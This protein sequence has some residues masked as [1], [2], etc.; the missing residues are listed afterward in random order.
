MYATE[1]STKSNLQAAE[2]FPPFLPP[3]LFLRHP[4]PPR[5]RLQPLFRRLSPSSPASSALRRL[6]VSGLYCGPSR[7]FRQKSF[8]S[9]SCRRLRAEVDSELF[10][11]CRLRPDGARVALVGGYG[12]YFHG[13]SHYV[14][15]RCSALPDGARCTRRVVENFYG[16]PMDVMEPLPLRLNRLSIRCGYCYCILHHVEVTWEGVL[17]FKTFPPNDRGIIE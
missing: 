4:P 13:R 16:Y 17:C 12:H 11:R 2:C 14:Q 7:Y 9:F 5:P 15:P 3:S 8:K 1:S 6:R 10:I